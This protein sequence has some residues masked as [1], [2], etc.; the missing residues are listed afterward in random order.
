MIADACYERDAR[1]WVCGLGG[2]LVDQLDDV[3]LFFSCQLTE[4]QRVPLGELKKKTTH[5]RS[6]NFVRFSCVLLMHGVVLWHNVL[7]VRGQ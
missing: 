7:S 4:Q 1:D 2:V 3:K 6:R 5:L